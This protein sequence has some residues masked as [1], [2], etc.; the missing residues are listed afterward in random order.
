MHVNAEFSKL[1]Q[2][3]KLLLDITA[4]YFVLS[5]IVTVSTLFV[6]SLFFLYWV[7]TFYGPRDVSIKVLYAIIIGIAWDGLINPCCLYLLFEVND[8]KYR[9]LCGGFHS[10]SLLCFKKCTKQ[11]AAKHRY[12]NFDSSLQIGLIAN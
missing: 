11:K 4:K 7:T 12:K 8:R 10:W 6:T 2:Q 1:N 9:R 3:Q 5:F